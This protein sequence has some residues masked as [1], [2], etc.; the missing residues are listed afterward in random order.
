MNIGGIM[1][2][3]AIWLHQVAWFAQFSSRLHAFPLFLSFLR[4]YIR[5]MTRQFLT[6]FFP[7][8]LLPSPFFLLILFFLL[9]LH[10]SLFFYLGLPDPSPLLS[11]SFPSHI[12]L[13]SPPPLS[14]PFPPSPSYHHMQRETSSHEY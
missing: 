4:T 8:P 13:F 3:V 2:S 12:P 5:T 9:R 14:P 11:R 10:F 7:T 1:P 6:L